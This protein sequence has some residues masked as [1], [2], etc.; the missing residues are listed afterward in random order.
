MEF[1]SD[2]LK[3]ERVKR[4]AAEEEVKVLR[5]M[6]EPLQQRVMEL[7]Q[8]NRKASMSDKNT[9]SRSGVSS[10]EGSK[11]EKYSQEKIPRKGRIVCDCGCNDDMEENNTTSSECGGYDASSECSGYDEVD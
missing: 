8:M 2:L 6:L 9:S 4:Q 3:E 10:E 7:I 5:L 1:L 11:K